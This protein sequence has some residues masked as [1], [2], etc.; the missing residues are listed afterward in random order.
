MMVSISE[1]DALN[2][3]IDEYRNDKIW[4]AKCNQARV[5]KERHKQQMQADSS[6]VRSSSGTCPGSVERMVNHG[7]M[8]RGMWQIDWSDQRRGIRTRRRVLL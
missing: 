3:Y 8:M 2:F 4:Q 1:D 7:L 6:Y 5:A